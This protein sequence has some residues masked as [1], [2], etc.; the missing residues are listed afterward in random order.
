MLR[1]RRVLGPQ[2]PPS[3]AVR[4]RPSA[5]RA[6][7]STESDPG[8]ET[9]DCSRVSWLTPIRWIVKFY[10]I[11]IVAVLTGPLLFL[12]GAEAMRRAAE[13][14]TQPASYSSRRWRVMALG[15]A[16]TVMLAAM[17][18]QEPLWAVSGGPPPDES[19]SVGAV[20]GTAIG[21]LVVV[22]L[23]QVVRRGALGAL[24]LPRFLNVDDEDGTEAV[25]ITTLRNPGPR[26]L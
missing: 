17:V 10:L 16:G 23:R 24:S 2:D 8:S 22:A 4:D 14:L 6:A 9:P 13:P 19:P 25:Q 7:G 15:A 3:P 11:A 26:A 18:C 1:R 12:A 5:A 20:A 21:G